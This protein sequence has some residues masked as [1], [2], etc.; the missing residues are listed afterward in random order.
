M[1][2]ARRAHAH[3]DAS[4]QRTIGGGGG[5]GAPRGDVAAGALFMHACA[6]SALSPALLRARALAAPGRP[7][8]SD[9][10]PERG[11]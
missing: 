9:E 11:T 4:L 6:A 8:Y 1:P 3:T 5:G 2:S 10:G 7:A